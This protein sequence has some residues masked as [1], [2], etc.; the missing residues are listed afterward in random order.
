MG[1]GTNGSTV[2]RQGHVSDLLIEPHSLIFNVRMKP[3]PRG[4]DSSCP[5]LAVSRPS[6]LIDFEELNGRFR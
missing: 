2:F 4:G 3:R 6:N 5:L 1:N